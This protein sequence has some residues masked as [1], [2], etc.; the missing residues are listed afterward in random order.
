[1]AIQIEDG[2]GTGERVGTSD[3]RLNVSSRTNSRSSYISRDEGECFIWTHRYDY[4]AGD[5]ILLVANES[6]TEDLYICSIKIGSDT[7]TEFAIHCPVYPTLAGTE[8]D[9]INM[10]RTSGK[11]ADDSAYGDE[12]GNTQANV[13]D[14]G[15]VAANTTVT[16]AIDGR[17]ILGYHNCIAVDLVTAGTMAT[18]SICGWYEGPE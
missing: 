16:V 5:T 12:T 6:T 1:M 10:N 9:E 15:F 18:V 2:L 17:V 4:D 13:V 8:I 7:A 3:Q 14:R 11:S